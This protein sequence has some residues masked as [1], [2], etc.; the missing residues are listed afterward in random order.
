M[1]HGLRDMELHLR[2]LQEI[3]QPFLINIIN[4]I[5]ISRP[6]EPELIEIK[7]TLAERL[8]PA[9]GY[10]PVMVDTNFYKLLLNIFYGKGLYGRERPYTFDIMYRWVMNSH[11]RFYGEY[12]GPVIKIIMEN[13]PPCDPEAQL[14]DKTVYIIGENGN[15]RTNIN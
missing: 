10:D 14:T 15:D 4:D 2:A 5:V 9:L 8:Y 7:S 3:S 12:V 13:K 1:P 11:S 6:V